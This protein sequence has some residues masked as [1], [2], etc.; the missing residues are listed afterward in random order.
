MRMRTALAKS[1]NMVSIR[2]LQASGVRFVQDY[3]TR[4]GFEATSTRPT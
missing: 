1:K 2:L 3:I 4:F